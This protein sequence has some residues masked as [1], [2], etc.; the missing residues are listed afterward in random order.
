MIELN[1]NE[2]KVVLSDESNYTLNSTD[3]LLVFEK[4]FTDE[5]SDIYNST[6]HGI[7]IYKNEKLL[8][9]ALICAVGGATGIHE[10]SSVIIENNILICC[11]N[12]VF[13]LH[14]PDL[15]LNWVRKG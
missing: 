5:E 7:K 9:N 8:T 6:K 10:N 4:I 13:S 15:S 2:Y 12:S 1:L 11:A 3:N 14:L